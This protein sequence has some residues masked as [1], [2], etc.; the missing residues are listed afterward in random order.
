MTSTPSSVTERRKA[1]LP[2]RLHLA[3][4]SRWWNE[5]ARL[6]DHRSRSCACRN[7]HSHRREVSVRRPGCESC[8]AKKRPDGARAKRQRIIHR[9]HSIALSGTLQALVNAATPECVCGQSQYGAS[10]ARAATRT[11]TATAP[12]GMEWS[13]LPKHPELR[14]QAAARNRRVE[15]VHSRRV[16]AA[17]NRRVAAARS[18]PAEVGRS[19]L[20]A[21]CRS[22]CPSRLDGRASAHRHPHEQGGS[23]IELPAQ[24]PRSKP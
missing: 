24:L 23:W 7:R 13:A 4:A 20:A 14:K 1:W 3:C 18:K 11:A 21:G 10:G 12:S 16:E 17:G 2:G 22:R 5:A 15:A 6:S 8:Y 9:D 19:K